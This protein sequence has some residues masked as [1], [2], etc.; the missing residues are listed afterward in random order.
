MRVLKR[1]VDYVRARSAWNRWGVRRLFWRVADS[2]GHDARCSIIAGVLRRGGKRRRAG[3]RRRPAADAGAVRDAPPVGPDDGARRPAL[4]AGS[5]STPA[6]R[7]ST[8]ISNSSSPRKT[9][10]AA[11][12]SEQLLGVLNDLRRLEP[13]EP[14]PAPTPPRVP[15][16]RTSATPSRRPWRKR[17]RTWL[18]SPGFYAACSLAA[19]VVVGVVVGLHSAVPPFVPP[20][21]P[22]EATATAR[23]RSFV[24]RLRTSCGRRPVDAASCA[25]QP[26]RRDL[27]RDRTPRRG[28]DGGQRRNRVVP[29]TRHLAVP[30]CRP[31]VR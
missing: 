1:M 21:V 14:A 26:G 15:P 19:L 29:G 27:V 18:R 8:G 12:S 30:S 31:A 10:Q 9:P 6:R 16:P 7:P 22:A 20:P 25:D 28:G 17:I 13:D 3:R 23:L 2:Q 5:R 11:I 4:A 24:D